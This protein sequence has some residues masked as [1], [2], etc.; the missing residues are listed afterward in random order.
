MADCDSIAAADAA[1]AAALL[2]YYTSSQVDALLV[3]YRTGTAQDAET[4][5]AISAALLAYYTSAQTPCWPTTARQARRTHRRRRPPR[6]RCWPTGR[7]RTRTFSRPTL[8]A[9][10]VPLGRRPGHGNGLEHRSRA[11]QLLHHHTGGRPPCG[12][13][14]CHGGSLGPTNSRALSGR[15]RGRQGGGSLSNWTVRG[16]SVVLATHTVGAASV[17]GYTLT[18]TSCAPTT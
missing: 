5:G 7:A 18:G 1:L 4:I 12:Q 11:A 9:G 15:W 16:C 13:A 3:D 8:G 2:A 10:G 14:R 17:D 6:A